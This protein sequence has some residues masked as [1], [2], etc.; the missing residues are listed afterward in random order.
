KSDELNGYLSKNIT[1][2]ELGSA[3]VE[4]TPASPIKKLSLDRVIKTWR[5][6]KQKERV[7]RAMSKYKANIPLSTSDIFNGI[8]VLCSSI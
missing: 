4:L 5:N 8:G 7:E 1:G 3:S 2:A 6:L